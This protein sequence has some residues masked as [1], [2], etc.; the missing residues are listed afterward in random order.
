MSV[1]GGNNQSVQGVIKAENVQLKIGNDVA[2]GA[3]VQSAEW[4]LTRTVNM[5]YEIG[6]QN[7]YYVGDRRKGEARFTRVVAGRQERFQTCTGH[8]K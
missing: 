6:T 2:T 1:F 7:V 3:V 4:T 8:P 5:L